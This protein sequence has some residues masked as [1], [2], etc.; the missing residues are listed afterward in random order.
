MRAA[1][2][3]VTLLAWALTPLLLVLIDAGV[4]RTP[5]LWAR[6][7]FEDDVGP[8][9]MLSQSYQAL[10]RIYVSPR[11]EGPQ[12]VLLG[13]SRLWMVRDQKIERALDARGTAGACVENLAVFGVG[14][15]GIRA[16]ARHA[17]RRKTALA[18]LAISG[19]DLWIPLD[20][21]LPMLEVLGPNPEARPAVRAID[22]WLRSVW[23]LYRLRHFVRPVL[24]DRIHPTG[25]GRRMPDHFESTRELFEYMRPGKGERMEVAYR[26][27]R[28]EPSLESFVRY[29]NVGQPR[30]VDFVRRRLDVPADPR[31]AE[32]NARILEDVVAGLQARGARA[33]LLLMPRNPL[34][35]DDREHL[36][37]DPDRSAEGA[38]LV[39]EVGRRRGVRVLDARRW[40]PVEAFLDFEH[41]MIDAS[42]FEARLAGELSH[43]LADLALAN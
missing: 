34:L 13:N 33:L 12:I 41:M 22:G 29:L 17:S 14:A 10:R 9:M 11:C 38:R 1:R 5:L 16:V 30:H 26:A 24:I 27:F 43:E 35:R 15:P 32:D 23:P 7:S 36:Y 8:R 39:L 19:S 6:T 18:L 3:T 4:T 25:S 31:I 2:S 20:N 28:R 40:L 21:Q 37:H 42:D